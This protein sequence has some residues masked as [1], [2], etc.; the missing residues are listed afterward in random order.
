MSQLQDLIN[1]MMA[2]WSE[3]RKE[4]ATNIRLGDLIA[5]LESAPQHLPCVVDG[6][7]VGEPMSYRGYYEDMAFD[8]SAEPRTVADVLA[9]ARAA[10][11]AVMQ[12]YKG[13]NYPLH[14]RTILWLSE[15]G[16]ASGTMIT[17]VV[18][19]DDALMLTTAQEDDR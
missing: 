4:A 13:G 17:G 7:Y 19:S 11:G 16:R 1:G 2:R 12:G 6:G 15:Y 5:E 9:D 18:L 10:R 14:D 8:T 3:E